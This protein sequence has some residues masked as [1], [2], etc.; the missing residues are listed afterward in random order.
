LKER[1]ANGKIIRFLPISVRADGK[2]IAFSEIIVGS[3]RN[4]QETRE[5]L[6]SLLATKGYKVGDIEYPEI[7]ASAIPPWD[8]S[9]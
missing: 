7:I 4:A 6:T 3:N 5:Q 2:R 1:E 8:P 9:S